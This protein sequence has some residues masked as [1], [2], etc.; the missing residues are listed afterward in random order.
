[1]MMKVVNDVIFIHLQMNYMAHIA[2][3]KKKRAREEKE[4]LKNDRHEDRSFGVKC[5]LLR[6]GLA[7]CP[8]P[9]RP[10]HTACM[11]V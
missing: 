2:Q 4:S 5:R 6:L 11:S 8:A 1:M 10:V 3:M 9:R 7:R